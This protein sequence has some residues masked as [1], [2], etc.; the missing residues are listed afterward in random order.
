VYED[1]PATTASTIDLDFMTIAIDAQTPVQGDVEFTTINNYAA[2]GVTD[3]PVGTPHAAAGITAFKTDK[4]AEI[5]LSDLGELNAHDSSVYI[6]SDGGNGDQDTFDFNHDTDGDVIIDH[7]VG[8][9]MTP[10]TKNS[11]T[12]VGVYETADASTGGEDYWGTMWTWESKDKFSLDIEYPE[13]KVIADLYLAPSGATTSAAT[14][15][16]VNVNYI[17]AA[18]GIAKTDADF[19]TAVPT[20]NV[21]LIGGPTVNQL[22]SDLATAGKTYTS[23]EWATM[24]DKAIVQ[25][26]EKAYGTYDALIIAGYEAKDTKLAGKVVASKL[27]Q[28][29]FT[30]KLKGQKVTL[31]TAGASTVNE[32]TF[33]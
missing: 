11:D 2:T 20:K 31:G 23:T 9:T 26:V 28:N 21:I 17:N 15:G 5:Q 33:A 8:V 19:A 1:K 16:A 32:V 24:T 3:S 12:K 29:Q 13:E 25:T 6:F 7:I 10:E 30:D 22:V 4:N 27:L 18:T 14:S